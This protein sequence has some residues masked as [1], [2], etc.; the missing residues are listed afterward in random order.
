MSGV[1]VPGS[2]KKTTKEN[3][4]DGLN[5]YNIIHTEG[6]TLYH[7]VSSRFLTVHLRLEVE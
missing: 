2:S 3:F 4:G 7:E 1:K 6:F 5:R